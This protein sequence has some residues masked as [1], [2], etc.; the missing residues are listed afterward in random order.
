MNLT[1]KTAP[2]TEPIT[3][4]EIKE[5]LKISDY[6]DTS[7]GLSVSPSILVASRTPGTVN[8]SSVNVTGYDATVELNVG[9]ILA[10]GKL[11]VKIQE[12]MDDA[13]WT[14]WYSFTEVTPANDN[15][16][17]KYK[18]TGDHVYI[19]VVAVL[20][21]ANA[22]YSVNVILNQGYTSE[23]DYLES[24]V[25][26]AR[27]YCEESQNRAY[28]T[29]VWEMALDN[30]PMFEIEIPIGNLKTVDSI[31]YKNSSGVQAT[32]AATEYI[33]SIRGITGSIVPAY[34]KSWP[35]FTPYPVDAVIVTFTCGYGSASDVPEKIK[36]AI[37][38]QTGILKGAYLDKELQYA[39]MARDN[40]L[41][42]NARVNV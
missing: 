10:T 22:D 40:L 4:V 2:T 16:T 33:T 23:D 17:F 18:Y 27:S 3:L 21:L 14:D 35:A 6:A 28:I 36:Q 24:L 32:L 29:Q 7:A 12:S 37:K 5:F 15:A 20:T 13:I 31:T 11:N 34:G 42:Q 30:F 9:T 26:S 41:R 25:T 38:L 8:G 19:R 1:L 39:I